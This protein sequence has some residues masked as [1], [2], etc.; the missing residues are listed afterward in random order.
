MDGLQGDD[1]SV[2]ALTGLSR[3]RRE[4]YLCSTLRANALFGPA[5]TVLCAGRPGVSLPE[6]LLKAVHRRGHGAMPD[7]LAQRHINAAPP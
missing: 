4:F 7:A 6:L 2:E 3:S 1:A 5:D